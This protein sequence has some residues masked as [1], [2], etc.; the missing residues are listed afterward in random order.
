M[1]KAWIKGGY[2]WGKRVIGVFLG[3]RCSLHAAGLT[4]FSLLALVPILCLLLFA[5]KTCGV[6]EYARRQINGKLDAMIA[7]VEKA[8][9]D[10]MVKWISS[11]KFVNAK[12]VEN[13]RIAAL[14]FGKQARVISNALFDRIEKFDINTLGWIGFVFLLWTVISTIGTVEDCFNLIWNVPKPRALWRRAYLYL[15]IAIVL[16]VFVAIA[17][18][19]PVLDAVKNVVT[20]TLGASYLTKWAGDGLIALL[21][22]WLF[23]FCFTV[24]FASLTF[25]FFFWLI[26]NRRV[27]VRRALAGGFVTALAFG[28]WLKLCAIAQIGIAN[29]SRL[30]GSFAILPILLAWLYMSWQIVLLGACIVRV[31]AQAG[32]NGASE[33]EAKKA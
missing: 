13:K 18:S 14:E 15:F 12:E 19:L 21:S 26:P 31:G 6:D 22:S 16:P 23:R 7:T 2:G 32:G 3:N 30:Y 29:S 27:P 9:D 24:F 25:A 17:A 20:A 33:I 10:D 8:Q 28:G 5:A 11:S 1:V 4:Y